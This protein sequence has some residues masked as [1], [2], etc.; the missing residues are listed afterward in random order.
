[1]SPGPAASASAPREQPGRTTQATLIYTQQ[2]PQ[3]HGEP[4]GVSGGG[5]GSGLGSQKLQIGQ[6]AR[7]WGLGLAPGPKGPVP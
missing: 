4:D 2:L 6:G 5:L 3:G 1:M 7:G